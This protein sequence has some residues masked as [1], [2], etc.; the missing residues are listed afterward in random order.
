MPLLEGRP[1]AKTPHETYF[2]R[3][4]AVR[5]GKWKFVAQ[6]DQLF[7]LEADISESTNVAEQYPEVM[8]R[9]KQLLND[10]KADMKVNGRPP[11]EFQNTTAY[12]LNT[13]PGWAAHSG[14]WN[15]NKGKL[16]GKTRP[17]EHGNCFH[18]SF[19]QRC[20]G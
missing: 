14:R 18:R 10:H 13:L 12:Y 9:L 11:G 16:C 17:N 1:D 19:R 15:V 6:K 3:T 7:D 20:R 2:Y 4:T 8:N 5:S